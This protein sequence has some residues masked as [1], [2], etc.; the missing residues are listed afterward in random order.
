MRIGI[1]RD[2]KEVATKVNRPEGGEETTPVD[3]WG[4]HLS[5]QGCSGSGGQEGLR[6]EK[7]TEE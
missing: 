6:Q 7:K 2:D 5:G 4:K 1:L 3:T